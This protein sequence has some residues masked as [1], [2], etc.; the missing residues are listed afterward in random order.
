MSDIKIVEN[1]LKARHEKEYINYK[2]RLLRFL[3]KDKI[4]LSTLID[5]EDVVNILMKSYDK[6]ND[7]IIF[8]I[9]NEGTFLLKDYKYIELYQLMH[10]D[11]FP[12][13]RLKFKPYDDSYIK[14]KLQTMI[15]D[16]K[17][18]FL[19]NSKYRTLSLSSI[20]EPHYNSPY[21]EEGV[22]KKADFEY[23]YI[24]PLLVPYQFFES[25]ILFMFGLTKNSEKVFSYTLY[26]KYAARVYRIDNI[27]PL[28]KD[29]I[30][31]IT[32]KTKNVDNVKSIYSII[33]G[34]NN[35]IDNNIK[36]VPVAQYL[37]GIWE[38]VEHV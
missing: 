27:T 13:L 36:V 37:D 4:T 7:S 33:E 6:F 14:R 23:C 3:A 38:R 35:T 8:S 9:F 22:L 1:L 2:E 21:W 30:N 25:H 18:F 26:W 29:L 17:S 32:D 31:L 28:I 11:I 16:F 10:P 20:F 5:N 12:N 24:T 15:N 34:F 19:K